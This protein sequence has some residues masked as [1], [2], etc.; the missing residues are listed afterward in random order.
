MSGS[1]TLS[2]PTRLAVLLCFVG[3]ASA[4]LLSLASNL[5][6]EDTWRGLTIAPEFRCSPYISRDY[7]YLQSVEAEIVAELGGIYSPYTLERFA[8]T[9]ETDIEHIVARS[10]AHDSGLCAAD[11]ATRRRFSSDLLNLTLAD[12]GLNR[13][14][15]RDH[16]ATLWMP[17]TNRCWF[18]NRVVEVR[19]KYGLTIDR[20][21]ANAL[22]NVLRFC[23]TTGLTGIPGSPLPPP[24]SDAPEMPAVK[25]LEGIDALRLWDDN[26][27]GRITCAEARRHG[28]APAPHGHPAYPFMRDGDGDGVVCE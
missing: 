14:M 4:G 9:R 24:M 2:L 11:L 28:I 15:K 3:L 22:E 12:P 27:N 19:R 23:L 25:P 10:E 26:R 20:L 21:E 13:H 16:D 8:S 1:I 18:A 7:S 6:A 17:T 5:R